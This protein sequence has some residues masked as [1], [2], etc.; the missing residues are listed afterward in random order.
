MH[1]LS[2][3]RYRNYPPTQPPRQKKLLSTPPP[4]QTVNPTIQTRPLGVGDPRDRH[5][6][7][8]D[9]GVGRAASQ[10]RPSRGPRDMPGRVPSRTRTAQHSAPPSSLLHL[11]ADFRSV[12]PRP[13]AHAHGPRLPPGQTHSR[14]L[15]TAPPLGRREDGV[16]RP[17]LQACRMP[18][19]IFW[20]P[21]VVTF[22]CQGFHYSCLRD[23]FSDVSVVCHGQG[24]VLGKAPALRHSS[25]PC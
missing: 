9:P 13:S 23:T 1:P 6:R 10:P 3:N 22:S 7:L 16:Q 4:S 20:G 15:P 19:S 5:L 11:P 12:R 2:E 14:L 24:R 17:R 21:L 8:P 25:S 18:C